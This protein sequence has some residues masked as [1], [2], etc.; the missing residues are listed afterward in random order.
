[1]IMMIVVAI[2][3]GTIVVA[4]SLM[5]S[6][7]I[8]IWKV[9]DVTVTRRTND[10]VQAMRVVKVPVTA[11]M[12]TI[13]QVNPHGMLVSETNSVVSKTMTMPK[14][15]TI[16]KGAPGI[17]RTRIDMTGVT[18]MSLVPTGGT[19]TE[20]KTAIRMMIGGRAGD[21]TTAGTPQVSM[22]PIRK[23]TVTTSVQIVS[24]GTRVSIVH[25]VMEMNGMTTKIV[26]TI[27]TDL[28]N[29]VL[30]TDEECTTSVQTEITGCMMMILRV[31]DDLAGKETLHRIV[32]TET[33]NGC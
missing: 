1:M 19:M 24:V 6:K 22:T 28:I 5:T 27:M 10:Q 15:M 13:T 3:T 4:T 25:R 14:T 18:G 21:I 17:A 7:T 29:S 23:I 20:G 31:T 30:K 16:A 26:T 2:A 8:A 9:E 11:S 32:T 33:G 12:M